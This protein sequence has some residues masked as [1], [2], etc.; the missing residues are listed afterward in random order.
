MKKT[1]LVLFALIAGLQAQAQEKYWLESGTELSVVAD[2]AYNAY[3]LTEGQTIELKTCKPVATK[4][5]VILVPEG[6]VVNAHVRT[7]LHQR[8]LAN[9]KR[10]LIID[11]KEVVLDDGTKI[12]LCDGVCSF[13]VSPRHSDLNAVPLKFISSSNMQIPTDCVMHAKVEVSKAITK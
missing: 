13:T 4:D 2:K 1:I 5:G 8:V 10:R 6:S 3:E 12:A 9:Q 11:L 7:G